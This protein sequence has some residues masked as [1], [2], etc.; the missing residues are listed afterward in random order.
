L[1]LT[2][3][4]LHSKI[5]VSGSGDKGG[6]KELINMMGV[7]MDLLYI[8]TLPNNHY[9]TT[10]MQLYPHLMAKH[11]LTIGRKSGF[12]PD[13]RH[14][15]CQQVAVKVWWKDLHNHA[16]SVNQLVIH[17]YNAKQ[18]LLQHLHD[19]IPPLDGQTLAESR[20]EIKI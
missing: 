9:S 20:Q 15:T 18:P 16:E 4:K 8:Y 5:S 6:L 11:C 3:D 14:E 19:G 10:Y 12:L 17:P 7:F 2:N 1:T 13:L